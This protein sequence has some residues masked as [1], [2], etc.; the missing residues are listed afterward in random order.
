MSDSA[1]VIWRDNV[2][3]GVPA[4][5]IHKPLKSAIRMWGADKEVRIAAIEATTQLAWLDPV[6]VSSTGNLTLSGEQ[7]IDGV[8]TSETDILVKDQTDGTLNGIYTTSSGAW[9]RRADADTAGE[10]ASA[11]VY[12]AGGDA[13]ADTAWLVSQTSI[14]L[15]T[16]DI[17][18][19]EVSASSG[20]LAAAEAAVVDASAA[21]DGA[22][23][24]RD[25]ALLSEG[26]YASTAQGIGLGVRTVT[27][28]A[29]GSGG[30]NGTWPWATT[31]GTAVIGATGTVTIAGGAVVAVDVD[32]R[33]LYTVAPTAIA[34]T[35]AGALA[36]FTYAMTIAVNTAVNGYFSVPVDP[37]TEAA[38]NL[39]R[40]DAGPVATLIGPIAASQAFKSVAVSGYGG[41]YPF[42]ASPVTLASTIYVI[43]NTATDRAGI[44]LEVN[45][46]SPVDQEVT[47]L[48]ATSPD[49]MAPFTPV[50]NSTQKFLV[51]AGLATVQYTLPVAAGVYP[52]L[53]TSHSWKRVTGLGAGVPFRYSSTA[54][55]ASVSSTT[56]FRYAGNWRVVGEIKGQ[57]DELTAQIGEGFF[58]TFYGP[59]T[60][61]VQPGTGGGGA[62]EYVDDYP[63]LVDGYLT[64][65]VFPATE[66]GNV[67][68]SV[69]D[70]VSSKPS[71]V[72]SQTVAVLLGDNDIPLN[73]PMVAGQRWGFQSGRVFSTIASP[74]G[75]GPRLWNYNST[76]V[77]DWSLQ[78]GGSTIPQIRVDF[79]GTQRGALT[80][81][82]NEI[83]A[84]TVA[85][86]PW[87]GKKLAA[88][89]DSMVFRS[90]GFIPLL[91]TELGMTL[92]NLG[93][94][95]GDITGTSATGGNVYQSIPSV[96]SDTDL[97]LVLVGTNDFYLGR[98][99]G[100]VADT[101]PGTYYG[102][103][104]AAAAAII[105]QA[106][107]TQIVFLS[108]IGASPTLADP[109]ANTGRRYFD[110]GAGGTT[111]AQWQ[112]A[113]IIVAERLGLFSCDWG[114]KGGLGYFTML[115]KSDDG[116][117]PIGTSAIEASDYVARCIKAIPANP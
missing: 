69:Y 103:L 46:D 79:E 15:G 54:D 16:T 115:T 85:E 49:G 44:G 113:P 36:G 19:I 30:T 20:L 81:A 106:P 75:G 62:V 5:G 107:D 108:F 77:N 56:G 102:A 3:E 39:Y 2:T 117:H 12:V 109:N 74:T 22:E 58:S 73:L 60:P 37:Q 66:D 11:R 10:L 41:T 92:Q 94:N 93:I 17:D 34:I 61:L 110:T 24:A 21:K 88:I 8:A 6:V 89:G 32:Q 48:L 33:G 95:G 64:R 101:V 100:T 72:S 26:L 91:A 4:S 7:T 111:L 83:A 84:L 13:N 86:N 50:A 35:G 65:L 104:H 112:E 68:I 1:S 38:A 53:R 23:T 76:L 55:L 96:A 116:L 99:L 52:V 80:I 87:V 43:S 14:V 82:R 59:E 97:T 98:A 47:V 42:D 28:T 40:V 9:A 31:G 90:E 45:F 63:V 25:A 78:T 29:A 27:I 67:T 114:R 18:F 105:A 57:V 70:M 51:K 71:K